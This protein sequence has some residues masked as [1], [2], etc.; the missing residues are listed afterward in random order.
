MQVFRRMNHGLRLVLLLAAAAVATPALAEDVGR[1]FASEQ[2]LIAD[3]TTGRVL[4]VLTDGTHAD[5]KNYPTHPQWAFDDQHIIFR[6]GDRD[7]D[8]EP[9]AFAVNEVTGAVTQL[10]DGPGTGAG[11]LNVARLSNRLYYMRKARNG[12]TQLIEVELTPLLADAAAGRM[13]R[14]GYERVVTT[15]PEDHIE[16]GGFTLDA[17]ERT[18][19]VGFDAQ[20]APPREP[21]QPVPQ[22]P[23][24]LRAIDLATGAVRTVVEVP[25]RMGHVQANP[26]RPGEILYCHET[27]GDAPQRMW[28]VNADG[29]GNRP[30]Y[31]EGPLDWVTHEQFADADHVI[32]NLMGHKRELRQVPT[33]ILLVNLRDNSVAHLGQIPI[34]DFSRAALRGFT[35]PNIPQD[36]TSTGGYWHNAVTHDG[37][38]AAG[39]DF[40]G[41][42]WLI[43]RE[44]GKRTLLS[45]GHLMRP[46][47][48]HP[49]FSPDGTRLLVQSGLLSNGRKLGLM[50]VPVPEA[51]RQAR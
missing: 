10:T 34:E 7:A 23:G 1:Q 33:G 48:A 5:A 51:V 44:N 6:S 17:D 49:S 8:G 14:D 40:D 20:R 42:V 45:T 3:R 38:W 13:K 30:V 28:I 18:A 16:A 9:Q 24:G 22:V 2:Q 35:D 39:D 41:N 43:D 4:T 31:A 37:R 46:D 26:F 11:S 25:F 19:Y 47:H 27:G 15:M 36:D 29:T 12:R 32:F 21:G 50:I